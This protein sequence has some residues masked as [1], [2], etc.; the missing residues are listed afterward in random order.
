MVRENAMTDVT[1]QFIQAQIARGRKHT[2]VFLKKGPKR[3]QPAAEADHLQI[4]HLTHLFALMLEKRLVVN[5][6]VMGHDDIVGIS[7]YES[8]DRAEVEAMVKADP[9]VAAGRL[10]YDILEWFGIDG[11]GYPAG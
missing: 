8:A 2:I 7:L 5:G 6:P 3:D 11:L 10:S 4:M 9:A 1:P